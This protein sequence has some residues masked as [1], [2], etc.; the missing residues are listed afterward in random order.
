MEKLHLESFSLDTN[1]MRKNVN[2]SSP[3]NDKPLVTH[4]PNW[5]RL[6]ASIIVVGREHIQLKNQQGMK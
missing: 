6:N 5:L 4:I 2:S 3:A 1:G